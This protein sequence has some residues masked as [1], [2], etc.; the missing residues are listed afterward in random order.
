MA[1]CTIREK[2]GDKK[3][4]ALSC[5]KGLNYYPKLSAERNKIKIFEN[6]EKSF[7]FYHETEIE[8]I[9]LTL[10]AWE[11]KILAGVGNCMRSYEIGRKKM[12]R[13]A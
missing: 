4:L 2:D 10:H 13:K 8:D 6:K 5:S 12:L 3:F 11:Q 1:Y 9:S 7:D